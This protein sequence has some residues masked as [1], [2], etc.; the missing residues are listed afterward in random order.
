M[1]KDLNLLCKWKQ[2]N[3]EGGNFF[4]WLAGHELF[5]SQRTSGWTIL[6]S[7]LE[8]TNFPPLRWLSGSN[9]EMCQTTQTRWSTSRLGEQNTN[10]R[11]TKVNDLVV[12]R[13]KHGP[14][15][16]QP[17]RIAAGTLGRRSPRFRTTKSRTL[18]AKSNRN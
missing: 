13:R 3:L 2:Q 11:E 8:R 4:K 16:P 14:S 6:K 10:T 12:R 15:C 1:I 5:R 17:G 7:N 18:L 9:P